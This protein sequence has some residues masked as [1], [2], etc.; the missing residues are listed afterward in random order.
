MTKYGPNQ[1]SELADY[2]LPTSSPELQFRSGATSSR[3]AALFVV[4]VLFTTLC[5]KNYSTVAKPLAM[6]R[7]V[8]STER[9][10]RRETPQTP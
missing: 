2:V 1:L 8:A 3:L 6:K 7:A 10:D 5:N 4:D 9:S